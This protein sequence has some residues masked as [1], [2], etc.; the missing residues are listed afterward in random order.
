MGRAKNNVRSLE[1][2]RVMLPFKLIE[3]A[4]ISIRPE[5]G[6]FKLQYSENAKEQMDV[7]PSAAL[8]PRHTNASLCNPTRSEKWHAPCPT[9]PFSTKQTGDPILLACM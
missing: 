1:G 5:E 3:S 4:L 6:A 8:A 7:H 9:F 2:H